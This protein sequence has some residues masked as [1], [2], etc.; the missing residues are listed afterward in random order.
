MSNKETYQQKSDERG[1]IIRSL[2]NRRPD[3]ESIEIIENIRECAITLATLIIDTQ[4]PSRERSLA[5][6]KIEEAVMWA[7]KG[8]ALNGGYYREKLGLQRFIGGRIDPDHPT[9]WSASPAHDNGYGR[10]DG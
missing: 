1:R 5:L 9:M 8:C 10:N 3:D 4:E 7:V 6:T 2:T